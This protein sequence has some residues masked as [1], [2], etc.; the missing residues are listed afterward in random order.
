MSLSPEQ[1]ARIGIDAA[2]EAAGWI[3]QDRETMNLAAGPG[4]AVREFKMAS[5]H[6]N[7]FCQKITYKVTAANPR[8]LIQ[9]FRNQYEPRIAVTV[10]MVATGTDIKPIEIVMF[11]RAV[12]SRVL[13]E[14][15]KGRGVR[16]IDPNDLRA[17]SGEDA[18]AKTHFVIVDCVG[19]TETQLAD[20]Q[21]LER[22]R[23]VSLKALL[24]HV[25]MGG[26]DREVLSSLA[27]RLARLDKRCGPEEHARVAE[28]SGGVTLPSI[29]GAIVEGLDPDRQIAEARRVFA[30][31]ADTE[32]T[33]AQI[34]KAAEALLKRATEPLATKPAL[35]TLLVDLKREL[36]Q[37]IDE[38]SEDELLEAGASPEAEQRRIVAAIESYF[39][40]LDAAVATLER[41]QRNLKRYRASVLK[42]AVEGRLVPTEAE[43]TRARRVEAASRRFQEFGDLGDAS[44]RFTECSSASEIPSV[45]PET[46]RDAA[47]TLPPDTRRD[48]ASTFFDRDADVIAKRG[49]LPH[50]QQPGRTYFVTFRLADSL[51]AAVAERIREERLRWLRE[52]PEPHTPQQRAQYYRLFSK[53]LDDKLDAGLGSCV[54]RQVAVRN[55]VRDALYYF[56]GERYCLHDWVIMPNHV[57]VLLTLMEAED[58]SK[59]LHSIKS[60]SAKKINGLL[61]RSGQLWQ[62]ESFDHIVRS[63]ESFERLRQYLADNP[64]GLA[65]GEFSLGQVEAASRRFSEFGHLGEA[66]RRFIEHS[67]ASEIPSVLPEMRRDAAST[68]PPETR[69]DAASTVPPD[70]RRDA[71]STYEPAAVLLT[72]ILAE[73]RRRWEEAELAK[74]T[75]KGKAPRDDKWKAKYVEPVAPDTSGLPELPEGWCWATLDALLREPLRNGHSAKPDAKGNVRTLTLSAV[76]E[77]DFSQRTSKLTGA[78]PEKVRDLWLEAGDIFVERSNTPEL[79]GTAALFSGPSGWAIFPDLLIRVRVSA[80]LP[81]RYIESVLRSDRVRQYFHR[82]AQGIAGSMPKISQDTLL[83]LTV[84]L[85]PLREQERIVTE[86]ERLFSVAEGAELTVAGS[87]VRARR[88]RQSILKW[89]FEG[90]LVDQ[91]PTDEPA[92]VLLER[93]R[94]EREA[95]K[96][97]QVSRARRSSP[98]PRRPVA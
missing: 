17:V 91:D 31:P 12:K 60:F 23:T 37:V 78:D 30:V 36:E 62:K 47:S 89:A 4:V 1:Q 5:G 24:E 45:P 75:A 93:I 83:G 85:P 43:L 55:I 97:P 3:I 54:L 48:A 32:P 96:T 77:R 79:V 14:Q 58:L 21:P 88:L 68:S 9:A 46:R 8:D 35:R 53:Q 70:A 51:P 69:R 39:T 72:R 34:Q 94:A 73:R 66:S 64:R 49:N 82:S 84:P 10:D 65:D 57:H 27:S 74:M 6:G 13:F 15:M 33:E 38:V 44:R 11:L 95:A 61:G 18:L 26:T 56:D 87:S 29:C 16:I 50:W 71:A 19:M 98:R 41:V 86:T 20:T 80:E 42:A 22:Q 90:R 2:L 76:T 40:R 63:A 59:V 7:A 52:N 92:S 81:P 28:A 67:S 25:A